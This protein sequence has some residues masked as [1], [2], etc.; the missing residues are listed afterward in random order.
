MSSIISSGVTI[1]SAIK[2]DA[3]Q[4]LSASPVTQE[5]PLYF[6]T[7]VIA[8]DKKFQWITATLD[9]A[10]TR[11]SALMN[12]FKQYEF[13]VTEARTWLHQSRISLSQKSEEMKN[14]RSFD[15]EEAEVY[16]ILLQVSLIM[17]CSYCSYQKDVSLKNSGEVRALQYC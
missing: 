8:F 12:S 15:K 11:V 7:E 16:L 2:T 3:K 5:S 14:S 17:R 4:L 10:N 13:K 1:K 9:E 6:S